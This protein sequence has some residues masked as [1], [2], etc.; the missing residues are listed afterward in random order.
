V[1]EN[2]TRETDAS[3]EAFIAGIADPQQ[4]AD[5][6]TLITL[7]GEITGHEPRMWGPSIVGFDAYHYRYASGREGDMAAASFSPRAQNLTLY[8]LDGVEAHR[9][10]LA[11]LGKHRTGKGC[12]YIR[13]LADVDLDVLRSVVARSYA[14]ITAQD[15]HMGRAQ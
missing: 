8:L 12:L 4:Q 3:V 5:A 9:D 15:G 11:V 10:E 1:A 13:R 6:R 14:S 2:R 7:L